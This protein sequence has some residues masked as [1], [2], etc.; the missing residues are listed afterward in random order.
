MDLPQQQKHVEGT[1]TTNG[2]VLTSFLFWFVLLE[3]TLN[4]IEWCP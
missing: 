1:I 4:R 3:I 2:S